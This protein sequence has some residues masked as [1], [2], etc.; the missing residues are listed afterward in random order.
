MDHHSLRKL[1]KDFWLKRMH[2]HIEPTSLVTSSQDSTAL[3]V[4]AGMQQL[5]P[6]FS[7]AAHEQ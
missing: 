4:V 3:F 6:F 1:W 2:K 5:V 7:G